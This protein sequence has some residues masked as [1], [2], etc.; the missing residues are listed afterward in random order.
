MKLKNVKT[1]FSGKMVFLDNTL[2]WIIGMYVLSLLF[3]PFET[4]FIFQ[5]LLEMLFCDLPIVNIYL[6]KTS[7]SF[8]C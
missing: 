8:F 3:A 5:K 1:P 6:Y 4:F 2:Q 7:W